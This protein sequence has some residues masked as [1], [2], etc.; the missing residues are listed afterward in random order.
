MSEA[1]FDLSDEGLAAEFETAEETVDEAPEVSPEETTT[2]EETG[3]E[4]AAEGP[5][6]AGAETEPVTDD[7]PATESERLYAGKYKTPE[8][9]EKGFEERRSH[10]DRQ[11]TEYNEKIRDLEARLEQ[12]AQSQ[13]EP[14]PVEQLGVAREIA[15]AVEYDPEGALAFAVN[16]SPEHVDLVLNQIGR[17]YGEETM[18]EA[19]MAVQQYQAQIAPESIEERVTQLVEQ[20]L[21]PLEQERLQQAQ[22]QQSR[23]ALESVRAKYGEEVIA[24]QEPLVE[25]MRANASFLPQNATS[26][27]MAQYV[28]LC[29]QSVRA[30]KLSQTVPA[31]SGVSDEA[32]FVE[33]G[34][35]ARSVAPSPTVDDEDDAIGMGIVNSVKRL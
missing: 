24:L 30:Q 11:V 27:Q 23:Q 32:A 2:E 21:A 10:F 13:P 9:L 6:D 25:A 16:E 20:R 34:K 18:Y 35:P 4:P 5:D 22:M 19:G 14:S 31:E 3:A 12:V 15:Q 26:E 7:E 28:D 17:M 8:E 33:T 29:F 1:D